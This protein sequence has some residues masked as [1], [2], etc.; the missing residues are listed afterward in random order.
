MLI[1]L[2]FQLKYPRR[3]Y[4]FFVG[5][6]IVYIFASSEGH[7][8]TPYEVADNYGRLVE[9]W[10][11]ERVHAFFFV[12]YVSQGNSLCSFHHSTYF[13]MEAK[14]KLHMQLY[15]HEELADRS[16]D[17]E[18]LIDKL[19]ELSNIPQ[20]MRTISTNR[21]RIYQLTARIYE[22]VR[23]N[24]RLHQPNVVQQNLFEL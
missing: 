13:H 17:F 15:S 12:Q 24:R 20:N 19:V 5:T 23:Y 6:N 14:I 22:I 7:R 9:A 16:A 1:M 11:V 18:E 4:F 10:K 2:K 8:L 21:T 3:R